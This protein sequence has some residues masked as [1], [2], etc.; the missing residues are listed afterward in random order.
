MLELTTICKLGREWQSRPVGKDSTMWVNSGAVEIKRGQEKETVW[1][2]LISFGKQG[3][4]LD[5]YTT[6]GS[7]IFIV[8]QPTARHYTAKNGTTVASMSVK[9]DRFSF[10]D[11]K[12]K[13]EDDQ[14]TWGNKNNQGDEKWTEETIP[15]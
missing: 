2:D 9:I 10:I 4:I 5:Q 6:K 1:L 15:F 11:F 14:N 8:G 12:P 3:E 13:Q 7:R